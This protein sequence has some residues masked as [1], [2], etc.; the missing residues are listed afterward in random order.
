MNETP[1]AVTPAKPVPPSTQQ[2][3]S[4]ELAAPAAGL[5]YSAEAAPAPVLNRA[6]LRIGYEPGVM[7][8]KWFT[9]WHERYGRTAPLAEIPLREGAGLEALTTALSTP[10]STSG[11]ARFE[12][13]AHMAIMRAAAQETPD[14]DRYHSIRLYE[15]V[16]VVVLPKDHVLTVLDEVPLGEMAE[17][18]LLHEPAE[19]P[20]WGEASQQW[21]QQNPRFL[22]QIPTHADA[23]ELV[24]AGVGLY[25]TPMSVAR[26]HHRKD[27]TYRPVPDAEPYPV[28]LVWPRIPAAPTPD[29]VQGEKDD[30][31]EVL[32][33]DFIGIVRGR[34]ASS[35]R[36][37]ET[38]QARRTRIAG[39]RAKATAKSRAANARRE[40]RHQK[41]AASRTGG[42]SR[43]K[44]AAGSKPGRNG[45]RTGKRR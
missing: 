34:T 31:F 37:S 2:E 38:A 3:P 16:P 12:P 21:R 10:N 35:N 43:R 26:L 4:I 11:E 9:R 1:E 17:E 28:H 7:P 6:S 24:A 27:L 20:A 5:I 40:A 29:T 23:I 32:I 42:T 36:G 39:E 8:G 33:Q 22:P 44:A 13:L 14:K 25:I 41:T 45:R 30:E 19:F 15:E 18:F